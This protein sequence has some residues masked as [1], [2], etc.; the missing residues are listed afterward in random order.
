M[1]AAVA[2]VRSQRLV[3]P[4]VAAAAIALGFAAAQFQAWWVAAPILERRIGPVAIEGRLVAVDPLPEGTRLI[5]EPRQVGRLDAPHLP[6]RPPARFP[7]D[8]H[9]PA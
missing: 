4:A 6:A 9:A 8:P 2:A 5:I 3:P 7:P 1:A